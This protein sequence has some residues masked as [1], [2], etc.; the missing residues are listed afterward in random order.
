MRYQLLTKIYTA[1]INNNNN[2]NFYRNKI[3]RNNRENK[4]IQMAWLTGWLVVWQHLNQAH[5]VA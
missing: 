4:K 3:T 5:R 2:N 1:A